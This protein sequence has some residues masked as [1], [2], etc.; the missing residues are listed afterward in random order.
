MDELLSPSGSLPA[1]RP[2]M[3]PHCPICWQLMRPSIVLF[4]ERLYQYAQTRVEDWLADGPVDML[5]V[6][7]TSRKVYPVAGYI[8]QAVRAGA[9]VAVIDVQDPE[10]D[11]DTFFGIDHWYFQGDAAD[12]LP[13]LLSP[14]F[15]DALEYPEAV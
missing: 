15:N 1:V 13:D 3:L 5:L 2:D 12:L 4:S 11:N 8:E 14:D 7:G 6:I 9:R 10:L